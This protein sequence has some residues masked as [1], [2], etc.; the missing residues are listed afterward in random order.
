MQKWRVAID[1]SWSEEG[2]L[3]MLRAAGMEDAAY[4]KCE[5]LW[6]MGV[7]PAAYV[8]A[9]EIKNQ[10][11]SD[12]NGRLTNEDWTKLI[13]SLTPSGIALPGDKEH[14]NLTN[15]QMGFLWQMLTGSKSTKNNPFSA[16]GGEKWLAIKNED[17]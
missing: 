1:N 17:K 9:Q 2:Q 14:F 8:R 16:A 15:V 5:A 12:G 3:Q 11:D 7:A 4:A 13:N 10:F 6:G